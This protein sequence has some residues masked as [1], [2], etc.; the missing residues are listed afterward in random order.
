M[1]I[2]EKIFN[3]ADK[4]NEKLST[5]KNT[6][7]LLTVALALIIAL[8]LLS[9]YSS[10][11]KKS[12]KPTGPTELHYFCLETEK[13]FVVKPDFSKQDAMMQNDPFGMGAISP[14]TNRRTAVPMSQCPSCKK[15]F[16]PEIYK[17]WSPQQGLPPPH[18]RDKQ[19][20]PY[21]QTDIL[22]WYRQNRK[23][24]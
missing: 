10:V 5:S 3:F 9:V 8:S 12:R 11:V 19:I 14:Y 1:S 13:E 6:R 17:T 18:N 2:A 21:C 15:W 4:I 23:K 22:D 7:Y 16:V 24:R 20:C